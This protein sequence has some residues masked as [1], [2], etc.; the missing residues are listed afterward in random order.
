MINI[1]LV[2]VLVIIVLGIFKIIE[3]LDKVVNYLEIIS[4]E[5]KKRWEDYLETLVDKN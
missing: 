3:K 1:F 4:R 5:P 2:I